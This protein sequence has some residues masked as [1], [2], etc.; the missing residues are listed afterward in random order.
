MVNGQLMTE[1]ILDY[2]STISTVQP[3]P[4]ATRHWYW[5]MIVNIWNGTILVLSRVQVHLPV[6]VTEHL[7]P[8]I[9]Y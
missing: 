5:Q 9:S 2:D 3:V 1:K 4:T 8:V 7:K 6:L